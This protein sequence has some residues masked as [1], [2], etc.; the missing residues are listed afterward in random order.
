M[1]TAENR[2]ATRPPISRKIAE[3]ITNA[4]FEDIP[5]EAVTRVKNSFLDTLG[6][7]LG[8]MVEAAPGILLEYVRDQG[9]TPS[10][11]VLAGNYRTNAPN[12]ALVNGTAADIVG[13]SDISV[14]QMTHP[15]V[16][17]CPAVWAMGEQVR[18][19]GR[20]ALLAH[21][22]GVEVADKL[23]AGIKPGFQ[24]KG[25][26]PLAVLNTF[27]AAAAAGKLLGL[28][29]D[30]M[31]HA[32]GI[33]G[34]EASGMRVVM[35]SMS[36]A[37]GAGRSA[38]DG[39]ICALLSARGYTGPH[40]V[41]EGRDGFLQTF[42]DGAS[43]AGILENL[44]NPFE[45]ISPGITLKKFPACTRSHNGIQGTLDLRKRHNI[46]PDDVESVEC[47]VTPAVVDYLKFS[48]PTS[49]FQAK[50]SMEFCVATAIRDGRVVIP[51]FTDEKVTDPGLLSLMKK[52]RMSVWDEYAKFGYNPPH[53]PYGCL[54]RIKLKNGEVV[55]QQVDQ[56]PWEPQT[57]PSWD[58]LVEKFR[59]NAEMVLPGPVVNQ[60][61]DMV[62]RLEQLDDIST[63]MTLVG[64][65]KG[66]KA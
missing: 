45:F 2:S 50:Y 32:L 36:K 65:N 7:A 22:I 1:D 20:D 35:G 3:F 59:A 23:G 54:I 34:A 64:Q 25:W 44:G 16:S 60:V 18:A 4:R 9:G 14:I 17:I 62:A 10:A 52:V 43:G 53:A 38:R 12:A 66:G 13:W 11:T 8:G 42:G 27:G 48:S 39:I 57:P 58:D 6:I 21:I 55:S 24:L 26:H 41:I 51:S 5:P 31:G 46:R 30:R 63:L 29:A 15:S 49:K 47:L 37:Y 19:T 28:D 61:I 40:D 33:A 56:G